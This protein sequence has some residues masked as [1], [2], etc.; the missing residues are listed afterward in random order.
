MSAQPSSPPKHRMSSGQ[1]R[2]AI[3]DAAVQLFSKNGFRGATTRQ[4]AAAVGVSEPVLYLHFQT[5]RD[6]YSAIIEKLALSA[7][8]YDTECEFT[9]LARIGDDSAFFLRLAHGMVQWHQEEPARIR[10]LMFSALEGHELSDLFYQR[11]I[12]PFFDALSKYIRQRIEQ[13]AFRDVDP[14]V[15]AR[16][17]CNMITGF[18]KDLVLFG[19]AGKKESSKKN[20]EAMVDIFL[21]GVRK[22]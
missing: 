17:F 4:L 3:V 15:A 21:C 11:H 19:G 2:A 13:G 16:A 5:K 8:S 7:P 9:A 14:M 10:L 20:L 12:V 6:L 18:A 1:R 22:S